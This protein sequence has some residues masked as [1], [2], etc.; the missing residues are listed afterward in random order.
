MN[1]CDVLSIARTKLNQIKKEAKNNSDSSRPKAR[2]AT[3]ED[4]D[5][6]L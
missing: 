2:K 6:F 5:R 3:Q 4:I 1:I